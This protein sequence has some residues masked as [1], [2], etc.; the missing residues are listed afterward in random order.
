MP[1][2]GTIAFV[3]PKV[4]DELAPD[5][6]LDP[7]PFVVLLPAP[8]A[9]PVASRLESVLASAPHALPVAIR[10]KQHRTSQR[11]AP[12]LGCSLI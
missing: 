4:P 6:L 10:I 2:V 9:G 7:E 11:R 5:P 8:L 12:A 1:V 3:L